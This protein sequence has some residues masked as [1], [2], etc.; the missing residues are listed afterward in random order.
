VSGTAYGTVALHVAPQ[1][2]AGAPLGLIRTGHWISLDVPARRINIVVLEEELARPDAGR[3]D[4]GRTEGVVW[5]LR[6]RSR[7]PEWEA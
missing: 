5:R 6:R 3:D 7:C 4:G 1:A 2:A